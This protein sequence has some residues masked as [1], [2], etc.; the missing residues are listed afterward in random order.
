MKKQYL[1]QR[2]W[3]NYQLSFARPIK[4][5]SI[6]H[7][8]IYKLPSQEDFLN[9]LIRENS[10]NE[11]LQ[12]KF[13]TRDEELIWVKDKIPTLIYWT[14]YGGL[15]GLLCFCCQQILITMAGGHGVIRNRNDA[16]FWKLTDQKIAYCGLCLQNK[17]ELMPKSKQYLLHKYAKRN[18][19][20]ELDNPN[21]F[22]S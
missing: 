9:R 6:C 12:T 16:R 3:A 7:C 1:I 18:Y 11:D 5:R 20:K 19:W 13:Q 15:Y 14:K 22:L 4:K 17:V 2:E 8:F 10:T 21:Y